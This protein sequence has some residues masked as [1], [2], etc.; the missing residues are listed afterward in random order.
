MKLADMQGGRQAKPV[1]G[2]AHFAS[3]GWLHTD[4]LARGPQFARKRVCGAGRV[5]DDGGLVTH[6][7]RQ[8]GTGE[9]GPESMR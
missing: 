6:G 7:E 1:E 2:G 3:E 9:S 5:H 4:G 8:A